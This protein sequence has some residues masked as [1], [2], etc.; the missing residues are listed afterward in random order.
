MAALFFV[1]YLAEKASLTK[2]G[3]VQL[4]NSTASTSNTL[5]ATPAAVKAAMDR[6]DAAFTSASNGKNA[7]GAAITGVDPAVVI[8][9]EPTF[10][11]LA[12]AIGH[13]STG[14]KWASGTKSTDS[15]GRLTVT[16][17]PFR[18]SVVICY[19]I[20]EAFHRAVISS[21][22]D[23]HK[24]MIGSDKVIGAYGGMLSGVHA[25]GAV[26][27]HASFNK[28]TDNGFVINSQI[29]MATTADWIAYE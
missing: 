20:N 8:P 6:A 9:P 24:V 7:V 12:G 11:D 1:S 2:A 5:A 25:S 17:L 27:E 28:I 26:I 16:N 15:T 21:I 3:H 18:P 4:S 19:A 23:F 13:I 10:N 29:N 14:K 22:N